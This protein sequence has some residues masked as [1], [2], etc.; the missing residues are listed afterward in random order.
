MPSPS[1]PPTPLA[2]TARRAL[3]ASMIRTSTGLPALSAQLLADALDAA[4]AGVL[5]A[6]EL[7]DPAARAVLLALWTE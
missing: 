1:I 7:D 3:S 2:T 6:A 4:S 5:R